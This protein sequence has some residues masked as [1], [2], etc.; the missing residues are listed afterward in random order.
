MKYSL[1][2]LLLIVFSTIF[3]AA[4][5]TAQPTAPEVE[6]A[7][8]STS[9]PPSVPTVTAPLPTVIPATPYYPP[10]PV[11]SDLARTDEQ[12]EVVVIV[13]P[14]NLGQPA[15]TLDF[16]VALD[17]HSID[18]S[19]DLAQMAELSTDKGVV[20]RPIK[21]DAPMGGHHVAGTLSF[22][23]IMDGVSILDGVTTLTIKMI[24]V[25]APERIFTWQ[26]TGE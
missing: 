6:P 24:E 3:L 25:A 16:D 8:I 26:L 15:E 13:T 10:D 19:M 7:V 9:I 2:T 12:G 22:P 18:L 1:I 21:W 14:M 4:C 17:T 11:E 20:V 23:A 5:T